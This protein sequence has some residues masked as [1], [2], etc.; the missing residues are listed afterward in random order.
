[1]GLKIE[2]EAVSEEIK[3]G[4]LIIG[5]FIAERAL[6]KGIKKVIFDRNGFLYHGR[7]KALAEAAREHGLEF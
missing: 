3:E 6:E 2:K 5:G 4:A 7:V 1:M